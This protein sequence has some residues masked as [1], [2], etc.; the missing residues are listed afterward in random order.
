MNEIQDIIPII[1]QLQN[2]S[3][4]NDKLAILKANDSELLRK[5]LEYTYNQFKKYGVSEK[6]IKILK[7]S[8]INSDEETYADIFALMDKLSSSNIND[9][10]RRDTNLFLTLVQNE[11]ERNL[12]KMMLLKDLRIGMEVKS[13]N[14]A[15]KGL[16]PVFDIQKAYSLEKYPFKK[17][18]WF[19]AEEKLNGINGSVVNGKMIS[20]Q[21]KEI[22]GMQHIIDELNQTSFKG[23]YFNGELLRENVDN[24]SNGENFRET[25]S[26]VNSKDENKPLIGMVVFDLLPI[27]EFYK[28]ESK[29]TYRTRLKQLK[30]LYRES[31]EL[32]LSHIHIPE[33]YYEGED[34]TLID[35]ILDNVTKNDKEGIMIIKD[36]CWKNKRHSGILKYKRFWT[37]DLKVI[38]YEEGT[39]RLKGTL[40]AL[41]VDYKGNELNVGSGYDDET[42]KRI[43]DN[44]EDIIGRIIEVKYKEETQDKKTKK[45][46]LQF[47]IF[48]EVRE[49]GKEVSYN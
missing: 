38:G 33:I 10:L 2:T 11:E 34:N 48:V 22:C 9:S 30:Q 12:Y 39:G 27:N 16:I 15:F 18:E 47:P 25:A 29:L 40:G 41:I 17:E 21:G 35:D 36:C 4:A 19:A 24:I 23:Y 1:K 26:I 46:S 32:G 45:Y 6:T 43:W 8:D 14:K 7:F 20:R 42:R 49:L 13:I 3:S 28:G 37:V 5:V 31:Q 44:K